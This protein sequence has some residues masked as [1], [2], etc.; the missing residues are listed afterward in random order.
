MAAVHKSK[1]N[2]NPPPKAA[3]MTVYVQKITAEDRTFALARAR[4]AGK[5]YVEIVADSGERV[6]LEVL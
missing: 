1:R 3:T 5:R 2:A 4:K 6:M